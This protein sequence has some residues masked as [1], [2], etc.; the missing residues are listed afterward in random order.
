MLNFIES[1]KKLNSSYQEKVIFHL[2]YRGFCSE[3]NNMT[4]AI[5]YCLIN[6]KQFVLF[7][8][9]WVASYS[10]RGWEDYFVPFCDQTNGRMH[11]RKH[12]FP[13]GGY[14]RIRSSIYKRIFPM[15]QTT[16]EIW[17]NLWKPNLIE[18]HFDIPELGIIGDIF[19]AKKVLLTE[20]FV[21]NMK[22]KRELV[23]RKNQLNLPEHYLSMH[24][25]RGDK[26]SGA[27]KETD[28]VS[29]DNYFEAI[30]K[31]HTSSKTLFVAT[32]DFSVIKYIQEK[33]SEYQ[34]VTSSKP[35]S[36]G[37]VEADFI[38]QSADY[39][40]E[41]TL[42]LL[43]DLNVLIHSEVFVGTF[44]SNIGLIVKNLRPIDAPTISMQSEWRAY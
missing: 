21:I 42:D 16:H 23:K 40:R 27:K 36:T 12:A 22:S 10:G 29:I 34:I 9:K 43:S 8:E 25:R 18:H 33:Y 44:S 11:Y 7:S 14:D 31:A 28:E 24:I 26:V 19:L 30:Q 5:L 35:K 3:I 37:F 20:L 39:R 6:K 17:G 13:S 38:T 1:Y 4:L 2:T 41:N 32:D 15:N